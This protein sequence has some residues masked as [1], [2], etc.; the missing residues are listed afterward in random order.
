MAAFTVVET[1]AEMQRA[2]PGGDRPAIPKT[3]VPI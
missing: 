3:P 2:P 1:M